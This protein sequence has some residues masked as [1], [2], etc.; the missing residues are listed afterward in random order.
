MHACIYVCVFYIYKIHY[1]LYTHV[2]VY[3]YIYIL[4]LSWRLP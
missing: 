1:I 3:I 2:Y 4:K